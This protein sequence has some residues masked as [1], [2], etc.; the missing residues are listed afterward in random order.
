MRAR[1]LRV[2]DTA[3]EGL[4][5]KQVE[6]LTGVRH[7]TASAAL[8]ALA[9]QGKA[10]R[11]AGFRNPYHWVTPGNLRGRSVIGKPL[12]SKDIQIMELTS[13]LNRLK[14]VLDYPTT[15]PY[16]ETQHTEQ[17][18]EHGTEEHRR[19]DLEPHH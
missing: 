18:Q 15:A 17:E 7:S 4:T 1:I 10:F 16:A 19:F 11:L 14:L 8:T 5:C 3:P 13:E 9:A 2:L 12:F 6:R